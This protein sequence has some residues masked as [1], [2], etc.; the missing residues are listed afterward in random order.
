[1][2]H[3]TIVE[4]SVDGCTNSRHCRS[5]C[6]K[7]YMRWRRH[8]NALTILSARGVEEETRFWDAVNK[9]NGCWEWT[10]ARKQSGYGQFVNS[11][12]SVSAHR[13]SYIL[14]FGDIPDGLSVLHRCDNPPCVR[15]DHLFLG[16]ARDNSRDMVSKGRHR[17]GNLHGNGHPN[18]K[19]NN[20]VVRLIR[21]DTLPYAALAKK[22]GVS[23]GH[24]ARI[25]A[26]QSWRHI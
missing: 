15:P 4:C 8:K 12:T 23:K 11:R 20:I 26:R 21:L 7:H 24:I 17:N 19:L 16:N 10:K 5:Y 9:S 3:K 6:Q 18:S 25:K 2:R 14:A 1:M 22:W 13:Y